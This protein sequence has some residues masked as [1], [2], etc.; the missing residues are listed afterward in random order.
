M[1]V[2]FMKKLIATI[3]AT[4]MATSCAVCSVGAVKTSEEASNE[5]VKKVG[6]LNVK[7]DGYE[8][9]CKEVSGK[10]LHWVHKLENKLKQNPNEVDKAKINNARKI[11][12]YLINKVDIIW[13]GRWTY[14]GDVSF[15]KLRLGDDEII[16]DESDIDEI[17]KKLDAFEGDFKRFINKVDAISVDFEQY[18]V[19]YTETSTTIKLDEDKDN[20]IKTE[21]KYSKM[22]NFCGTAAQCLIDKLTEVHKL[23]QEGVNKHYSN[24]INKVADEDL[25]KFNKK[26]EEYQSARSDFMDMKQLLHIRGRDSAELDR[27][28]SDL[29][30]PGNSYITKIRKQE[31]MKDAKSINKAIS[32]MDNVIVQMKRFIALKINKNREIETNKIFSTMNVCIDEMARRE[33]IEHSEKWAASDEFKENNKRFTGAFLK[34]KSL[35]ELTDDA[36]KQ[37]LNEFRDEYT[38]LTDLYVFYDKDKKQDVLIAEIQDKAQQL[39]TKLNVILEKCKQIQK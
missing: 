17:S 14:L 33:N 18:K 39:R 9:L 11:I 36:G 20:N 31:F 38:E 5:L 1:K 28:F 4:V 21:L 29:F 19:F 3:C 37:L 32:L 26:I 8:S 12:K 35:A 16:Y 13:I 2:K 7:I 25:M 22:N 10:L 15:N 23:I 6:S 34:L 27:A 30:G 24:V